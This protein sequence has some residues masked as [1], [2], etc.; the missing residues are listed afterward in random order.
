MPVPFNGLL[1]PLTKGTFCSTFPLLLGDYLVTHREQSL[2]RLREDPLDA[3]GQIAGE[4]GPRRPT[5]LG[6]ARAAAYLDGRLRRAGLRVSADPFHAPRS[7][8]A[9]GPLLALPALVSVALY[10]RLPLPSLALTLLSLA[11]AAVLLW[12]P[13]LVALARKRPSQN[14][15]ATRASSSAPRRRVVLLAP[16]DSPPAMS[17]PV[18]LL[19]DDVRPQIGRTAAYGLLALLALLALPSDLSFEVRRALWFAQFVPTA[20]LLLLATLELWLLR[21]PAT[22]GAVS[23]A[24]ALAV[25]LTSAEELSVLERTELWAVALG[26]TNSGA[27]LDDF[28]RRYPFDQEMTLFVEIAGIGVGNL[29]YVTRQGVLRERPADARLLQLAAA[30]DAADPLIDA[31]PRAYR[32]ERTI[33]AR[34]LRAHRR[35]LMITC[36]GDDGETP[37]RGSLGDTPE[38]IDGPTLDRAM[39]LVAGLVRQID[40]SRESKIE[41]RG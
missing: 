5:S 34:L 41:E 4:I 33:A 9:D 29:S 40:T 36:L 6:E 17:W 15:I 8:G 27:G 14:V 35:A 12:R 25:L 10:Y 2:R 26:A 18:R 32:R 3:T 1:V 19:T 31:E 28:L 22:P 30:A 11:L 23:H 20:Y 38:V 13:D 24:G 37:Y 39:R 7:S 21:A 16:L